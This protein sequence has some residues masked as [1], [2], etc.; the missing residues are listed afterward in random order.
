VESLTGQLLIAG[1]AIVDPNF[2]RTIV[3]LA[4]H[5]EEG[6]VGVVLNR[7]ADVT[8]GEAAPA[9]TSLVPPEEPLFVG[10]PM[11]PQSAV[12][13]AEFEHPELIDRVAFGSI[14]F[15][16]DEDPESVGEIRR[17]RV[18][19]GYA[20]WG[21]GQLELEMQE[22]GS[23]IVEPAVPEDVFAPDPG[24]LWSSVLRRKGGE[25]EW[26]ST[27]PFDPGMN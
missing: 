5:D 21:E 17:A 7:P 16:V 6:A 24:R 8:V 10:G 11:Q 22:E 2:R 19:A 20:G 14:G 3:L 13:L 9:L 27:M 12:V 15:L 26:L 23:W 18:F 4:Q 25:F 1:P